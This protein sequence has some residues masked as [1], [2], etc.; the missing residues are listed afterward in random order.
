MLMKEPFR[1]VGLGERGHPLLAWV[2]M[3]H[4]MQGVIQMTQDE[5]IGIV[6]VWG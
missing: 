1:P 4:V 6:I 5:M 3:R 2:N